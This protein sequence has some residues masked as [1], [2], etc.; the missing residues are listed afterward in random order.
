MDRIAAFDTL[1]TNNHI[2]IC[3]LLLPL[4]PKDK[5]YYLA[6][7]IKFLE[8]QHTIKYGQKLQV[9]FSKQLD[10]KSKYQDLCKEILPYCTPEEE[11]LV[12]MILNL[13]NTMN[14]FES[15]KPLMDMLGQFNMSG[16]AENGNS[17]SFDFSSLLSLGELFSSE[18]GSPL[19]DFASMADLFQGNV[20][21]DFINNIK[22]MMSNTGTDFF[23]QEQNTEKTTS[24]YKNKE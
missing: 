18:N 1:Y 12:K 14:T 8:L 24:D 10:T 7:F 19:G 23:S 11:N 15:L 22:D 20:N 3:K 4:L 17:S 6:I 9:C 5:Q 21:P 16:D 2:Q 13:L